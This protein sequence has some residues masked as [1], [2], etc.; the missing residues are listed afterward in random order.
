MAQPSVGK[1]HRGW[2]YNI[3]SFTAPNWLIFSGACVW[4]CVRGFLNVSN[5]IY[6]GVWLCQHVC[7]LH[8]VCTVLRIAFCKIRNY[9][10][11]LT[12]NRNINRKTAA[13]VIEVERKNIQR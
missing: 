7:D 13:T 11:D 10:A 3:A 9:F 5:D 8:V 12:G 1:C 4:V 2:G 6:G